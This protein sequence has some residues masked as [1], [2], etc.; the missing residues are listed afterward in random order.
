MSGPD[1]LGLSSAFPCLL[2]VQAG[3]Q[4]NLLQG[5]STLSAGKNVT[6]SKRMLCRKWHSSTSVGCHRELVW[7]SA[8]EGNMESFVSTK[9]ER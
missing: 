9:A 3:H 1:G 6:S 7:E 5:S 4:F 2:V 8:R